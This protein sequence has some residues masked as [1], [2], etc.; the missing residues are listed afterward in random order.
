MMPRNV[1]QIELVIIIIL[2]IL[3]ARQNKDVKAIK[4]VLKDGDINLPPPSYQTIDI[5]AQ[6]IPSANLPTNSGPSSWKQTTDLMGICGIK[7]N[8]IIKIQQTYAPPAP[9]A[10]IARYVYLDPPV[11][12]PKVN[13]AFESF[14]PPNIPP[15]VYT[16]ARPTYYFT[17]EGL[18]RVV[19]TS[20]GA[21]L[22]TGTDRQF[23]QHSDGTITYN[24]WTYWPQGAS[25]QNADGGEYWS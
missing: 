3:L 23:Q 19:K 12:V 7:S 5:P 13:I 20:D 16:A 18:R 9:R 8:P 2:V 24:G 10:P 11:Q 15:A 4:A 14:A 21:T 6:A 17:W 25:G 22:S 1:H